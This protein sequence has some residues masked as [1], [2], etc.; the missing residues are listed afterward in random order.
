MIKRVGLVFLLSLISLAAFSDAYVPTK[1]E[2]QKMLQEADDWID[3]MP[4]G[5]QDRLSD[6]VNH[7]LHGFLSEIELYR[8]INDTTGI[9][10]YKVSVKDINGGKN[11][12]IKMR[13]YS[14][15]N[16]KPNQPVLVYFH[17]GGWS[18]G[19]LTTSDRFCRALASEGN[20]KIVSVAYPLAPEN[21][22]PSALNIC[23]EAIEYI[24][25]KVKDWGG[26]P[27]RISLG[28]DGAGGNLAL[29]AF[30]GLKKKSSGVKIKSL[31][32]YYPLLNVS[33]PLSPEMRRKFGRGYGMDSRVLEAFVKAYNVPGNIF[34]DD[35]LANPSEAPVSN[36]KTLPPVLLITAGRDLI[37]EDI[38]KFKSKVPSMTYVEFEGAIHGFTT[39]NHQPTAFKKSVELTN[40][41][42]TK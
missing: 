8:N 20:V 14:G 15:K 23:E 42:L 11:S 22:Y 39:D 10:K 38:Q 30:F 36:L 24:S 33:K 32:L 29:A 37:I 17:G 7:S 4:D 9:G 21:P 19:S 26:D 31:V 16:A 27:N 12:N 28:G 1:A 6:A 2:Q 5:L 41:F 25:G 40:L 18:V 13:L 34:L 3:D 35:Y